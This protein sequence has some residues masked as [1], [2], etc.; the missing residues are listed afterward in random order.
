[1]TKPHGTVSF[2][3]IGESMFASPAYIGIVKCTQHV[4]K[5]VNATFLL[6]EYT[7]TASG[8]HTSLWV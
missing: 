1:M 4:L 2:E 3:F 8:F 7:Y 5:S 6:R